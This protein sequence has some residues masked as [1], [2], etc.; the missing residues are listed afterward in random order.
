[1]P[2]SNFIFW[3][4]P[5]VASETLQ[6]LRDAGF[7][8]SLIITAPDKPAGR[9]LKLTP[10]PVKIWA[11]KN[12]VPYTHEMENLPKTDMHVVVA[13]GYIIPEKILNAPKYGSVNV[14][15]SL[16]PKHR[17][18]SPVESAILAG[19]MET[20][21]T[22]QKM[23]R[24]LDAG[25]ILLQ[26]RTAISRDEKAPELRKKLIKMGAEMLI[27][28]LNN[29]P[30][31]KGEL[32]GVLQNESLATF[33]QKIEKE[34]GQIDLNGNAEENYRKFRAYAEWPRTFFF[35]DGLPARAGKRMIITDAAL[36]GGKFIIKKI[37]PEGGKERDY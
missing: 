10:T 23:V 21:V 37:I 3:G 6:I 19:D 1:M 34:D 11:M 17:G 2:K 22:L 16:L 32:K 7:T 25:P 35:K 14:H 5:K 15:Y 28:F 20:G 27:G 12:G 13:Y 31:D 30:P 4:T 33:C 36:E 29:F 24:K 8:P 9:G 18:A 26:E